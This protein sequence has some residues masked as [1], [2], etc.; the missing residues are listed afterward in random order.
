MSQQTQAPEETQQ[1]ASSN[2]TSSATLSKSQAITICAV[3]LLICFFL[4]WISFLG[5]AS[6]FDLTKVGGKSLL[7]WS[8]PIFSAL[9]ILAGMTKNRSK[10][11]AQFTGALPFFVLAYGL[12]NVGSDLIRILAI[13]GYLSLI[14]GLALFILARRLK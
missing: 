1:V 8:L 11:L 2:E 6:G 10:S 5:S 4:P 3:G 9:T 7:L 13:G 12:Y 14:L